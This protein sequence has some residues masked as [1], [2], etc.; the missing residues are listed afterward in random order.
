MDNLG[1]WS[2]LGCY[3]PGLVESDPIGPGTVGASSGRAMTLAKYENGY[4]YL[5]DFKY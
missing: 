4:L 5:V 3:T 1:G 2:L